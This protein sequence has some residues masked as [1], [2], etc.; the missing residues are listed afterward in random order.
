MSKLN[1]LFKILHIDIK[2]SSSEE[3]KKACKLIIDIENLDSAQKACITKAYH[4]GP[5]FD[6]DVPSQS[7]RNELVEKGFMSR[8]IV[9]QQEGYNACTDKGLLA[10]KLIN[11]ITTD[12]IC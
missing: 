6:I 7:A 8:I 11:K 12:S 2:T 10:Y 1:N 9:K 5:L 4:N 3:I